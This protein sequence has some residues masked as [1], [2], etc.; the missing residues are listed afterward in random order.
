MAVDGSFPQELA[1]TKPYGYSLFNLDV[2]TSL[3]LILSR[4]AENLLPHALPDGRS[5]IRSVEFLAPYLADKSS[6]PYQ[7]DVMCWDE[8][9]V[10][11]PALLFGAMAANRNDWLKVWQGLDPDPVVLEVRRNYPIRNA[12][13][14]LEASCK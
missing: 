12:V 1:R 13:I 8:W 10:R 2:M 4:P 14:W 6:W 9:P 7:Q 3:A 5:V 11:Q